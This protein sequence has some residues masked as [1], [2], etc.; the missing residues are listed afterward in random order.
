ML[1]TI[2]R[3]CIYYV[4]LRQAYLSSPYYAQR[5]SSRT[6]LLTCVP[7]QYCD[8][9][10]L[11][12]LYG[13]SAKRIWIPRTAKALVNLVKEREQ[14][15]L[16]LE[17]AEVELIRK[18]NIAR[19]KWLRS[20]RPEGS[21][22]SGQDLVEEQRRASTVD[23]VPRIQTPPAATT[24]NDITPE[25]VTIHVTGSKQAS[26]GDSNV[27]N[28]HQTTYSQHAVVD[29]KA[30]VAEHQPGVKEDDYYTHPYGL[31]PTLPDIRGSV[32]AKWIPVEARPYHRPLGN[33]G[34]RVDTI[35]WTRSRL[36]ELNLEIY[37]LRR[38]VRRGDAT[39]LPAAFIEFDTQEAAQA[40]H[41][42]VAHHRPLQMSTRLLG[43]RS[44]EVIWSSLRMT[45]WER[46]VRKTM[47]LALISVAIIFWSIP[48]AFIGLVSNIEF[49]SAISFLAWLKALPKPILGFIQGFIPAL[50]L[51][52]W[53]A[54]VPV[55]LRGMY[56]HRTQT[57]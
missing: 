30:E 19:N 24:S 5:L 28:V 35:R 31:E 40:A 51:S 18:A 37:K 39:T 38:R 52:M 22:L 57:A 15:A 6:M 26:S 14:T 10:R 8:E 21:A 56:R 2:V 32:A 49:L 36:K 45:W 9:A 33:F 42:A 41:Q 29:E 46:V 48:S 55:M 43:V 16:R 23:S 4:N 1:V 34:R 20:N 17:K 27:E 13:D 47:V 12:K 50:A 53:M 3:E 25:S 44:D 7:P 54:L 11:R